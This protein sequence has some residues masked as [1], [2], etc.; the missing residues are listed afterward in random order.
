[1]QTSYNSAM[2]KGLPGQKADS[3]FD[4]VESRQAVEDVVP[5]RGLVKQYGSDT[6]ARL[7]KSNQTVITDDAGTFTAGSIVTTVNGTAITTAF[8]T[9][10]DTTL[11]AHAAAIQAGV[12]NVYSAVY[13]AGS[14]TIT[15]KTR[16]TDL[17]VTVDVSG[18]TG[19]MTISSVVTTSLDSA[20]EGIA[21][22]SHTLVQDLNGLV[23][24]KATEM[25]SVLR[26]GAAYVLPEE[27]VTSDDAV[28]FRVVANGASKPIGG[29]GKSADSGKCVAISNAR[30]IVGGTTTSVAVLE[31]GA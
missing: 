22:H 5:G 18:I 10:K 4:F 27:T 13:S 15:I 6:Q 9:N 24:Y 12:A 7:P 8:D 23:T 14:H 21:L 26:E 1:M 20:L 31:I 30:W 2:D 17:V 16:N 25:V 29:F 19:N 11:T 28:Y 3:R